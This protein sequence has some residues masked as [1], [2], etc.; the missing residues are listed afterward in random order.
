MSQLN[1]LTPEERASQTTKKVFKIVD[2]IAVFV[3]ILVGGFSI[4][5]F[6]SRLKLEFEINQLQSKKNDLISELSGY[7]EEE[8]LIRNIAK[9]Y[10][11]YNN[12][13]SKRYNT[14]EVIREL[15]ARAWQLNLEITNITFDSQ[16]NEISIRVVSETDQF[17]KFVSNLKN[18]SFSGEFSKYPRLF[19][20]S[21]KNEQV[22]QASKEYIV[23]IKFRP[24][25]AK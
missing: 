7:T 15:Y 4:F 21:E 9:R 14:G 22:N 1:L 2:I 25:E 11:I 24:E 8:T 5:A 16:N 17:S 20:A 6:N 13:Q 18:E 12:F 23:F 10:E 19:Y 3:L